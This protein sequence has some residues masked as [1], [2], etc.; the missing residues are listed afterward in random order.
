MN[1]LHPWLALLIV[2]VV[3]AALNLYGVH[4]GSF[5]LWDLIGGI[6]IYKLLTARVR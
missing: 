2:F 5:Y 4:D 1:I 6:F 3:A